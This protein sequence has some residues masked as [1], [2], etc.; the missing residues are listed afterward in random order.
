MRCSSNKIFR[1]LR[2]N[3]TVVGLVST[4]HKNFKAK[5]ICAQNN[6]VLKDNKQ[7]DIVITHRG[8]QQY[9]DV[10]YVANEAKLD[11]AFQEKIRN[12]E[13]YGV[14][15]PLV[16]R[17]NGV[18]YEKSIK[19]LKDLTEDQ[20]IWNNMYKNIYNAIS[21]NWA[22]AEKNCSK[23]IDVQMMDELTQYDFMYDKDEE[24]AD[25][26]K[27]DKQGQEDERDQ[28]DPEWNDDEVVD[29]YMEWDRNH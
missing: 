20:K 4:L 17:Y 8:Q 19:L 22:M 11:K 18:I 13:K 16:I 15:I 28:K 2:H 26:I 29:E 3:D 10:T 9:I 5:A 23:K 21:R 25:V 14:I 6:N 27:V 24:Y 12:Y 1:N 7:P